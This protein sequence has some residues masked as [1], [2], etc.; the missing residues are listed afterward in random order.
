MYKKSQWLSTENIQVLSKD[1]HNLFE[2]YY[3]Y[4]STTMNYFLPGTN[5][6]KME[7]SMNY[8]RYTRLY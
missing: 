4:R 7:M 8:D 6:N 3:L 5:P 2:Y 1:K